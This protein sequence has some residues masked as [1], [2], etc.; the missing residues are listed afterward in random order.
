ME[1]DK[2]FLKELK[3]LLEKY[4]ACISWT[5]CDCSDTYGIYEQSMLIEVA[6]K[7]VYRV[8]DKS[9][10]EGCNIKL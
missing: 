7:E 4:N 9:Y 6:D 8:E 1:K 3:E 2:Q 10:I 5:C